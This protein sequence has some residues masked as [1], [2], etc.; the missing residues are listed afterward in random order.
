ME[1][2]QIASFQI[3]HTILDRGLYISRIDGD[4]I[5]YDIRMKRPNISPYLD[6]DAIHTIEHLFAT[7]VRSTELSQNII[8]FGPMGC[9]TGFYFITRGLDNEKVIS[10]T[11]RAFEFIVDFKGEIPGTTAGECGNYREHSLIKAQQ[12]VQKFLPVLE[13]Y[14]V[15][16][17]KYPS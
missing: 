13:N 6:N 16:K 7:F 1:L 17:L 11:K 4:I 12:E 2:K 15:D 8:Y 14:T 9:R 5:T 10:L 3:D